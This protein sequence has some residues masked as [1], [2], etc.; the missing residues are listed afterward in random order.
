[1]FDF[2]ARR[3]ADQVEQGVLLGMRPLGRYLRA[4]GTGLVL[5]L[6]SVFLWALGLFFLAA[7]LFFELSNQFTYVAPALYVFAAAFLLGLLIFMV[8]AQ[9]M[10]PRR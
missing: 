7:S 4:F 6:S 8:G 10:R 9:T 1:M 3:I 2:L 5:M